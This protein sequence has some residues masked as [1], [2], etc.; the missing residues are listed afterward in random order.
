VPLLWRLHG[1]FGYV[2][3][4]GDSASDRESPPGDGHAAAARLVKHLFSPEGTAALAAILRRDPLLAFDFD[5]TLAPIVDH[6]DDARVPEP[7]AAVLG[8]AAERWPVAIVTGRDIADVRG[9]L[10]FAPRWI[11]GNHGAED[12]EVVVPPGAA[13]ALRT[14]RLRI[15]EKGRPLAA[16][17]VEVET[18]RLSLALHYRRAPDVGAA[19]RAIEELLQGLDPELHRFGGKCVVNVA[20]IGLPDKGEALWSLV[21]R[22]GAGAAFFVGDDINDEAVFRRAVPPWLTLR[23]GRDAPESTAMFGLDSQEE[24]ALALQRLMA[25]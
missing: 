2:H 10:G 17:G 22:S 11:V 4:H 19:L 24:L 8:E 7:L 14:L 12:P 5:G 1:G 18:K 20:A 13:T 23:I 21:R 9:R 25:P 16:A 6:P 15:A 3:G